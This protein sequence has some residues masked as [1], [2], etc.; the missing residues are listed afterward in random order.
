MRLAACT[1][2]HAGASVPAVHSLF[3]FPFSHSDTPTTYFNPTRRYLCGPGA[4]GT[5]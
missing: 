5:S 3:V 2:M 1:D 4:M